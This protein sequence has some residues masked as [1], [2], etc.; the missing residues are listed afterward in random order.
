MRISPAGAL[1]SCGLGFAACMAVAGAPLAQAQSGEPFGVWQGER[2]GKY[3]AVNRD[4]SCSATVLANV[5]GQCE[6]QPNRDRTGG[7]LTMYYTVLLIQPGR[8][9]WSLLWLNRN[10]LLVNGVERYFRR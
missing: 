9:A 4:G 8:M 5:V 3:L 1:R 6:W 2:S 7:M 10:S